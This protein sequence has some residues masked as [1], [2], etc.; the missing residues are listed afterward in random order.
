[1][2]RERL[3]I[4]TKNQIRLLEGT[5][6]LRRSIAAA[7]TAALVSA[8]V[9]GLAP[10][11][12]AVDVTSPNQKPADVASSGDVRL[13][14]DS[15]AGAVA[16][17]VQIA[18][19]TTGAASSLVTSVTGDRNLTWVPPTT[20]QSTADRTLYWRVGSQSTASAAPVYSG[21]QAFD[22]PALATPTLVAPGSDL[23]GSVVYPT[24]VTFAWQ[25]VPGAQSYTVEYSSEGFPTG[26]AVA[27]TTT[28]T[29]FTPSTPL[30]RT[31][32]GDAITWSWRVRANFYVGTSTPLTGAFSDPYF[33]TIGWPASAS[34]PVLAS[35]DAGASLSDVKLA[36]NSV[37]GAASYKVVV[38]VSKSDDGTAVTGEVTAAEGTTTATTFVPAVALL[39]QNYFWQVVP[40]DFAGNAGVASE[41]RQFRKVWGSQTTASTTADQAVTYPVPLVGG[42]TSATATTMTLDDF[43]LAWQPLPRATMYQVE[44][45]PTNGDPV[46]TCMTASTSATIVAKHV[47]G[48]GSSSSL[49]GGAACLWASTSAKRIQVGGTYRW[50]VRGIDYSGSA[51]TA[52]TTAL[53]T[54]TLWSDW[55]DPQDAGKPERARFVTVVPGTTP[56]QVALAQPDLGAWAQESTEAAGRPSPEFTWSAAAVQTGSEP[57]T[58][59]PPSGYEVRIA[60]NESMT[61]VV[62]SELTPSTTMRVNGVFQDNQTDLPY[63]WQ[64]RPFT[65]NNDGWSDITYVGDWSAVHPSWT[66]VSTATSFFASPST[67]ADHLQPVTTS[68]DGTVLLSWQPQFLTAPGD[69]GSRGYQITVKKSDSSTVGSKK[70]EYPWY[71]A[72]DPSTGKPLA[73]GSYKFV[74]QPLDAN[75]TAGRPSA[76]L[77]FTIEAPAPTV[78]P[79]GS[80]PSGA[81]RT[82]VSLQWT[83]AAPAVRYNV[84]YWNV[85]TP[86]TK[87][88]VGGT[89]VKQSAITVADLQPGEY[90]WHVQSVDTAGNVSAWSVDSPFTIARQT[91]VPTTTP[92]AV[93]GTTERVLSWE[94][95]AGASR[96]AVQITSGTS[97]TSY[98]T[99]ATSFA[100]TTDLA[101]GTTY[102][103]TVV[104]LGEKYGTSA[105]R[106]ALGESAARTFMVRT[107]PGVPTAPTLDIAG[108]G[109]AVSWPALSGAA[110]GTEGTVSYVVRYRPQA[111]P[112]ATWVERPAVT[113]TSLTISG[114]RVGTIYEVSVAARNSEGQGGWSTTRTKATAGVPAAPTTLRAASGLRAVGLSWRAPASALPITGYSLRWRPLSSSTWTTKTLGASTVAYTITGLSQT[115]YRV[116]LRAVSAAGSSLPA[117]ADQVSYAQ[118]S[119]PRSLVVKR[120]DRTATAT[121]SA[122]SSLGGSSLQGYTVQRSQYSSTE[123]TWSSW[124]TV[125]T[126]SATTRTVK[127]SNLVNGTRYQVRIL[128]RT[129]VGN[130][131][132]TSGVSVTPAGKPKAPTSVK[133]TTAK[134]KA[135]VS[136]K[137]V[138]S[139]GSTISS[140]KI[141]Y[142]TNG[143]SW[144]TLKS[145]KGTSSSYTWTKG[146]KGKSYYVRV[147]AYNGVGASTASSKV[148][149]TAK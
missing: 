89:T 128:A 11:A 109:L 68:A 55:S 79:V 63:Y 49:V 69:G 110:R 47:A 119:A 4:A 144:K 99:R 113:G 91:P 102:S 53:P 34:Q 50:R 43:S 32:G 93:L 117:T 52:M 3:P 130:G 83:A 44:V 73:A 54:G 23:G 120:G 9:A 118:A 77:P 96:Y 138:A 14:W 135:K 78:T 139:N 33:F 35:P 148:K 74:V 12:H 22:L 45:Y 72:A 46:L 59:A 17:A 103:W 41:V 105:S 2:P 86:D 123:K 24:P 42:Q 131:T 97:T 27:T 61:N 90:R 8:L 134:K 111:T 114:L 7:T 112:E 115:T 142:S 82:S 133:V 75:G 37:P 95:V 94:P 145:V 30:A 64:V 56:T 25:P 140:Y 141:Q 92:G 57:D 106:I 18:T 149:F 19:D 121:W 58:F 48:T 76:E 65:A 132:T 66:K 147:I 143:T 88:T 38:G 16:Y 107:L 136:W 108:T 125:A 81:V 28:A 5:V 26:S 124:A 60:L 21:Y 100:P 71:V 98:E 129:S 70:V 146:K 40:L 39:D 1:M 87:V 6:V 51:T 101:Y 127:M 122:P 137:K 116:E 15:S 104:P 62:A 10:A 80:A 29:T 20:I 126:T 31:S 85:A 13:S 84:Q 67:D 36:W